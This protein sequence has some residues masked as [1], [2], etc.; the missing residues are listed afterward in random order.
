MKNKK[1]LIIVGVLVVLAML[2]M[3]SYNGMVD[4]QELATKAAADV[5]ATYQRR[6]DLIPS[7]VE[8]VK[9]YAKH[10]EQTLKEVVEARG[11]ATQMQIDLSS[12]TPEQIKQYQAA[13]G[14]LG[15]ALGRLIAIQEQYPD[16][17]A[18]KQFKDLQVQLEGTEN[19]INEA[20]QKFNEAVTNYN[21]TVRRFP[22]NIMASIFGFDKM[23]KFEADGSAQKA[24]EVKF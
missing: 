19:R 15:A 5:Q 17:K 16:L 8:T 20:R 14:E 3:S 22:G 11:K 4:K 24:P 9:G 2:G 13:Q 23:E 12:A 6:A 1:T 10:E 18:S 21:Q 7:L